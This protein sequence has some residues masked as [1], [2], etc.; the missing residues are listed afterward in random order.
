MEIYKKL[1][2]S[3]GIQEDYIS[4]DCELNLYLR[5]GNWE[6]F[7]EYLSPYLHSIGELRRKELSPGALDDATFYLKKHGFF[8]MQVSQEDPAELIILA[9]GNSTEE[10]QKSKTE[11]KNRLEL[12][13]IPVE[14]DNDETFISL[15]I[16]EI[17]TKLK[18]Q[19]KINHIKDNE[20]L[21]ASL[22]SLKKALLGSF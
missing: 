1:I 13:E 15:N 21:N 2:E 18:K 14:E 20:E 12:M 5:N 11:I 16:P 22:H 9:Q 17:L 8:N 10:K 19:T 6:K 4:D 7:E 3:L